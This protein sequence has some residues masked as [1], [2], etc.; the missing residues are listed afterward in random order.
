MPEQFQ[1]FF[2]QK[3][4]GKVLFG[5]PMS[6][7]TSLGIGGPVDAMAFPKDEADL[8]DI[9]S[10]AASKKFSVFILGGGTNLLVRDKGIR[11]I[12]VNMCDGFKD[13]TWNEGGSVVV[14]AGMRLST[15]SRHASERELTGL[16][17]ASGIPGTIGGAVVM[18]AGAYG[19]EMKDVIEGIEIMD[20]KGKKKFVQAKDI[21]FGY[22]RSKLEPET[23]IVRAHLRLVNGDK[24][25]IEGLMSE[26][27]KKR[28]TTSP[29][30]CQ[31][32]GSVFKNPEGMSA[33][34]LIDGAGLKG[35]K[36]GGAE[37]S[38]VHANYIINTGKAR[39]KDVLALMALIRD[40]VYSK[41]GVLLEPEIKVVGE[42]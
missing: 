17:F 36:S 7:Y 23:I 10:F 26:Y 15:L 30:K 24:D 6:E 12:V 22:R 41:N 1:L 2:V 18:N 31:N 38:S 34:K 14:G 5:V 13:V 40:K 11:G 35:E 28:E 37:I 29:I 25:E 4:K 33:G 9:L 42:D 32:A 20:F 21:D 39:A 16:E 27:K 8:K 3:F 19:R